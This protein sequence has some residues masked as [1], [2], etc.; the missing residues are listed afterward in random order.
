[1]ISSPG[2]VYADKKLDYTTDALPV[3]LKWFDNNKEIF[4]SESSQFYLELRLLID[5]VDKVFSIYNSFRKEKSDYCHLSEFQHIEFE[6][7]LK[8]KE[9]TEIAIG[10]LKYIT[11]FLLK[12]NKDNLLYFLSDEDVEDLK[13]IFNRKNIHEIPF[14]KAL[15]MLY[16]DTGDSCYKN[17][18]MKNFGSWEEIRLTE[19]MKGHVIVTE[20]PVLEIPFYH[21]VYRTNEDGVELAQNADIILCGFRETVGSGQRIEDIKILRNKAEVFNLPKEDYEPYLK[22]REFKHYQTTSGFGMGWQRYVQWLLKIPYIWESTHIPRGHL[23]P[24]P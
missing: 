8:L 18:S 13:G 2:E 11:N 14:K 5:N 3:K 21:N 23:L 19:L 1:M 7:K 17:F 16:A 4:L 22:T 20:F 9:N 12:N 6:G 24:K 10:L 15:E